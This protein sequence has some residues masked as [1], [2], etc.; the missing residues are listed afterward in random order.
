MR[1]C[2]YVVRLPLLSQ[3]FVPV[4]PRLMAP[5]MRPPQERDQEL[6]AEFS[7]VV[8]RV[9]LCV[10]RDRDLDESSPFCPHG[11]VLEEA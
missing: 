1:L 3:E 6:R 11:F 4:L 2:L 7:G 10:L 8:K 9:L 5:V